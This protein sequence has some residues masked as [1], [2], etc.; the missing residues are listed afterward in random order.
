MRDYRGSLIVTSSVEQLRKSKSLVLAAFLSMYMIVFK[1]EILMYVKT[2]FESKFCRYIQV[3]NAV[4]VPVGVAL[5]YAFGMASQGLT[6]DEP[7]I[8]LP[9]KYPECMQAKDQI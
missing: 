1:L 8:K 3:G 5:G 4:A 6:D 2:G 9:F 7:V